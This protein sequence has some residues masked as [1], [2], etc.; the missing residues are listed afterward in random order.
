MKILGCDPGVNGGLAIVS[1]LESG[2]RILDAIDVPVI[3]SGAKQR[4][5]VIALQQWLLVHAP[6]RAFIER[7]QAMPRKS[8]APRRARRA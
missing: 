8:A 7:A 4:V 6:Y 3:G 5:D 2:P 1:L